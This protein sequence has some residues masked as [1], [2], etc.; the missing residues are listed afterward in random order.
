M[1]HATSTKK[2]TVAAIIDNGEA[3]LDA[4]LSHA[5][6]KFEAE[7]LQ[8][9]HVELGSDAPGLSLREC[10]VLQ[11]I[12]G[13]ERAKASDIATQLRLTRGGVSKILSRLE[14]KGYLVSASRQDNRKERA[15]A[16]TD[17]G[18][19]A[20]AIHEELHAAALDRWRRVLGR[21]SIAELELVE[22]VTRDAL[23]MLDNVRAAD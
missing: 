20:V 21:Y 4:V 5:E 10:H 14:V 23:A 22:G 19:V 13:D 11:A 18:V 17:S 9:L 7:M 1:G 15:L 2:S 6:G 16:L 8:R 3:I 12:A